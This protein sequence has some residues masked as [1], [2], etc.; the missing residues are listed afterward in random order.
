MT[1]PPGFLDELRARVPLSRV[2]GRKV[3][4]DQRRSNPSR[5][6]FWAPC[7]F[8]EERTA[9]FHVDDRKGFFYCFGCHAKGDAIGFVKDAENV[10]FMEAVEILARE[11]GLALPARDPRAAEAASRSARL[12][13]VMEMAVR[14][15]RLLLSRREGEQA[16][17][18]LARRGLSDEAIARWE[19]GWAGEDR[20]GLSRALLE[21]GVPAD[22][23]LEAGLVGEGQG[24]RYDRFWGRV[25]FPIRDARGRT[26]AL[27]GRSLD[28]G[29]RAKYLNSPQTPIFDKGRTLF[30]LARAREAVGR[31]APLLVA[32]GYMDVIALSEA[33]LAGAVA[34]LGTAVTAE[35]L[36]LLWGLSPEPVIA[37]DGDAAGL[38][39]GLRLVD[40]ALPRMEAGQGLRFA[41][42][43]EGLDPDDLIRQGG[44]AAMQALVD[45]AEPA[46]ALL[47]RRETEGQ[48]F[49]SPERRAALDRRL[50]AIA[51]T[52]RDPALRRHYEDEF[53]RLTRALWAPSR[54]AGAPA[55]APSARGR[56]G[57]PRPAA[58]PTAA[59]RRSALALPPATP[60]RNILFD[61]LWAERAGPETG[62][63]RAVLAL[64]L[65]HP[66]LVASFAPAIE[67]LD[68]P[69]PAEAALRDALLR[70]ADAPDPAAALSAEIGAEAVAALLARAPL[71]P[72]RPAGEAEEAARLDL[73]EALARLEGRQI[74]AAALREGEEEIAAAEGEWVTRHLA[75]AA[76]ALDPTRRQEAEDTRDVILAPNG[77][78]LDRDEKDRAALVFGRI[79]YARRPRRP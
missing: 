71:L 36:T 65:A 60:V 35:Q 34:P 11:A 16:R 51:R 22:L 21:K 14:H 23:L 49:D 53:R 6:D 78:A 68:C 52:V 4:W 74:H 12:V 43:P 32:E 50:A 25:I 18:Y 44:R 73:A 70:H 5:G 38:R 33:G 15:Y 29:A 10:S 13:E 55:L 69:D 57:A 76:A 61:V 77:V 3:I 58:A 64:C 27:G 17:A 41:L 19:I 47:W 67:A 42:L 75:E 26:V 37:L 2:V 72:L 56:A 8:H 30:N 40:L 54:P 45:A 63:R 7:P 1:L 62:L 28:P 66:R 31:G 48:V 39:A 24:G 20:Q 59:A 79:D 46:V 9:S